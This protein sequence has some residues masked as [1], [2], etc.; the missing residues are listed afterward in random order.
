MA[1]QERRTESICTVSTWPHNT[2]TGSPLLKLHTRTA[3]GAPSPQAA[4]NELSGLQ[5]S[6]YKVILFQ[7]LAR[8]GARQIKSRKHECIQPLIIGNAHLIATSL[9]TP[10]RP[11]SATC[12]RAVEADHTFTSLASYIH[13]RIQWYEYRGKSCG[14]HFKLREAPVSQ[15]S[16]FMALQ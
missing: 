16:L 4:T 2:A 9:T 11:R 6:V 5:A 3:C 14:L 1:Q 15:P 7:Q 10:A 12:S 13:I 8:Q